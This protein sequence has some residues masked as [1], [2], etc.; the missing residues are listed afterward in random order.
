[1]GTFKLLT[2]K[3]DPRDGTYMWRVG[4][5]GFRIDGKERGSGKKKKWNVRFM[6][7]LGGLEYI[8]SF[9]FLDEAKIWV[10]KKVVAGLKLSLREHG[11][12]ED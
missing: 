8:T 10:T 3:K 6:D 12:T 5:I 1:M 11:I 2:F 9:L 7:N 4:G